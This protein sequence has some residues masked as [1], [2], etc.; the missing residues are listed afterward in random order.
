MFLVKKWDECKFK[1][2]GIGPR[3]FVT[4]KL[5]VSQTGSLF[6]RSFLSEQ[7]HGFDT[8]F[9]KPWGLAADGIG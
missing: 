5:P 2:T 1:S 8:A 7:N 3:C 4:W 6:S 9:I